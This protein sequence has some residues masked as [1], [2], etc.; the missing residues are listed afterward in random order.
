MSTIVTAPYTVFQYR[1]FGV[2]IPPIDIWYKG[3]NKENVNIR[4]RIVKQVSVLI[5]ILSIIGLSLI[6]CSP[7]QERALIQ[8]TEG[9]LTFA[10]FFTDG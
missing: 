1:Q 4:R 10:F 9:K 3:I 8:P 2:C 5:S 7:S 6:A